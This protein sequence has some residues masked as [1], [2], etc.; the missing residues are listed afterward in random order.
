M[1]G[2]DPM[3]DL[4][5]PETRD[6]EWLYWLASTRQSIRQ[7]RRWVGWLVALAVIYMSVTVLSGLY[8]GVNADPGP[9]PVILQNPHPDPGTGR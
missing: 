8:V 2:P 9:Q 4:S 3:P 7:I 5:T 1:A 6:E